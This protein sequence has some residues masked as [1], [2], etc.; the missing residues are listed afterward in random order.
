MRDILHCDMNNFYASVECVLNPALRDYPIAVGGSEDDRHGIILAKNYIAKSFGVATG[1]TTWQARAKCRDLIIVPPHYD[2]YMKYSRL[3]REIYARYTDMIEPFG[4]DECWLDVTA[5]EMLFGT[6]EH[7]ADEIRGAVKSEL[8]LT[9]S[10]GVSFNKI[11]AKL[12]S[13]MKKPDAITVLTPENF[14]Q[15]AWPLPVGDLFGVGRAT[16]KT[17]NSYGIYTIGDLANYPEISLKYRLG[18]NGVR[19][20]AYANGM[21]ESAVGFSGIREPV[22]SVSHG[23]TFT[24]NLCTADDVRSGI[25]YLSESISHRLYSI[26]R[27]AGVVSLWVKSPQLQVVQ[28]QSRQHTPIRRAA[29]IASQAC[30][31]YD[32]NTPFDSVRALTV[33][34]SMLTDENAPMEITLFNDTAKTEKLDKLDRAVDSIRCRFGT[35]KIKTATSMN[36]RCLPG[37]QTLSGADIAFARE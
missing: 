2:A 15:K 29:D 28:S 37:M 7:I 14:R 13:D 18:I 26:G 1:E 22:K 27:Y 35:D 34:V 6:P 16:Q 17:L 21:D 36:V 33:G 12:G 30:R 10:I 20:K 11:F 5:S 3:A 9:I 24:Q 31:L 32:A 19:L 8:G 25:F 23:T 4:P